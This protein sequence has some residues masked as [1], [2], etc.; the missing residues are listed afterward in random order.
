MIAAAEKQQIVIDKDQILGVGDLEGR[1]KVV[2]QALSVADKGVFSYD[3]PGT[4]KGTGPGDFTVGNQ[5]D[6]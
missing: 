4:L 1:K 6:C 2:A 5:L 3:S